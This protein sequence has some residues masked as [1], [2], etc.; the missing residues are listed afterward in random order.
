[1]LCG[2]ADRAPVHSTG[3]GGEAV[4]NVVCLRCG[5]V[6]IERDVSSPPLREQYASGEFSVA[7]RGGTAPSP[8]KVADSERAALARYRRLEAAL[9]LA[10]RGHALEV[11]CGSGS[12]LWLLQGRGWDVEGVEPDPGY[13]A[14]GTQRYGVPIRAG[15]YEDAP[16]EEAGF[17]LVAS[18]HVIEHVEDPRSFLRKTHRELAPDG[19]LYLETPTIDHPRAGD[20]DAFF[21]SA[22]LYTFSRATLRA[23]LTEVGFETIE[24]GT[25][26]GAMWMLARRGSP[27]PRPST[28]GEALRVL[29]RARRL[30]RGHA[31]F[32]AAR[33][34]ALRSTP[35]SVAAPV[36]S[37][38]DL[39][40]RLRSTALD[41]RAELRSRAPRAAYRLRAAAAEAVTSAGRRLRGRP[42]VAHFGLHAPGNA[43][44]TVLFPAVRLLLDR[45]TGPSAWELRSLWRQVTAQDVARLNRR[46][47]RI[48]VGGG[49]L[50]LK[51][52]N[53]NRHSGW[54]WDCPLE[55]LRALQPP[56]VV[57][58][59]GYN[60]FRS[61][62]EF[63]PIFTE[64]LR[65]TVERSVFFGLRNRG[66]IAKLRPYL[67]DAALER[68]LRYQPC[69]TTLLSRVLP[70]FG[71]SNADERRL[72]VNVAFD[73][74]DL[75]F[76]SRRNETLAAI[77]GALRKAESSGWQ[78]DLVTHLPEDALVLPWLR[79]AGVEAR[80]VELASAPP[81][82]VMQYYARVPLTVGMRGH[83][84]MIP[85][86]FGN[87]ILSLVSH[88]KL[89]YFLDD[90]G[91]P[92]WGL[93]I[94]TPD[95]EAALASRIEETYDKRREIRGGIEKAQSHLWDVSVE[96]AAFLARGVS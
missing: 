9:P 30:R 45:L 69:P 25:S 35:A 47:D 14:S 71:S 42:R 18:F 62:D 93:E 10:A 50:L 65:A 17:D 89:R 15:F 49:G 75:R 21:W 5:L 81:S 56:L 41:E 66:S 33:R 91:Q 77:S 72:A 31:R 76:G 83:S 86:G 3:R 73:R 43:G 96:N 36:R 27:L 63:D 51:D 57:Y 23:L 8:A 54:Q 6:F 80:H 92:G 70:G 34:L 4:P 87:P 16:L 52:T 28:Q 13:A 61:Q 95:L 79:R 44:D 68:K 82:R 48:V 40:A 55:Q 37:A 59:V 53:A 32:E 29:R 19:L 20:L 90:I 84:Q 46:V 67:A 94:D 7:A 39:A 78:I 38:L 22:H 12:F 64:H 88:D 58:A 60:R 85:F 26:Q 2:G 11:G 1:M 74:S 24:Y